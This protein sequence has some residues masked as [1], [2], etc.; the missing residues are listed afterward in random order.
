MENKI[1]I[2]KILTGSSCSGHHSFADLSDGEH[3]WSFDIVPIFFGE[4]INAIDKNIKHQF[5]G[6]SKTNLRKMSPLPY[7][8]SHDF[9]PSVFNIFGINSMIADYYLL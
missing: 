1:N 3:G 4:G 6:N 9:I 7:L 2:Y 8:S 5:S